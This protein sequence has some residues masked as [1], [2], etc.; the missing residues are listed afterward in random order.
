M[1]TLDLANKTI[2]SRYFSLLT[3][4]F[5]YKFNWL[6]KHGAEDLAQEVLTQA[7]VAG[8][9]K[10]TEALLR[11][12]A[13]RRGADL[14]RRRDRRRRLAERA[15]FWGHVARAL[16]PETGDD[17]VDHEEGRPQKTAFGV[18]SG[19]T[20]RAAEGPEALLLARESFERPRCAPLSPALEEI[21]SLMRDEGLTEAD[22]IAERLG[23]SEVTARKRLSRLH[24]ASHVN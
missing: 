5:F 12:I 2:Y 7:Y 11:T 16:P 18:I 19:H 6:S 15:A 24:A 14:C 22:E 13:K 20:L 9:G 3:R 1:A 10:P 21:V 8:D 4:K 17:H 23:I